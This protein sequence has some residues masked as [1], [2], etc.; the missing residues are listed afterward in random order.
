M[1]QKPHM[2]SHGLSGGSCICVRW[3]TLCTLVVHVYGGWCSLDL[4]WSLGS[5]S[6]VSLL[7]LLWDPLSLARRLWCEP[8]MLTAWRH[9]RARSFVTCISYCHRP[10]LS[11]SLVPLDFSLLVCAM[12]SQLGSHAWV[13]AAEVWERCCGYCVPYVVGI[14]WSPWCLLGRG[15]C[16]VWLHCLIDEVTQSWRLQL[17]CLSVHCPVVRTTFGSQSAWKWRCW[18]SHG[19]LVGWAGQPDSGSDADTKHWLSTVEPLWFRDKEDD[20]IFRNIMSSWF[21]S[22]SLGVWRIEIGRKWNQKQDSEH[23]FVCFNLRYII[24]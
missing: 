4:L 23:L 2:S 9:C 3:Q 11:A 18:T 13:W 16:P 10:L 5:S 24:M 21:P 22:L 15:S 8:W 14:Q 1:V 7:S 12:L 20:L 17:K 6:L 19:A